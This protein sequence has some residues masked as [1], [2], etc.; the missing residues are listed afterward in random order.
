MSD[1]T[2]LFLCRCAENVSATVDL[3]E[4]RPEDPE[5][6]EVLEPEEAQVCCGSGGAWGLRW[7]C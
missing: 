6:E 4:I 5:E 7:W 1:T 2:V 3:E